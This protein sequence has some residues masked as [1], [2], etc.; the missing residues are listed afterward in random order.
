VANAPRDIAKTA[1]KSEANIPAHDE[2][3]EAYYPI[4]INDH[5]SK[6]TFWDK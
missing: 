2:N 4:I 1:K 5:L 6:W 3:K